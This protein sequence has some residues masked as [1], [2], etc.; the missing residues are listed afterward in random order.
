MM[1]TLVIPKNE[2]LEYMAQNSRVMSENA[3]ET[4]IIAL[5][6]QYGNCYLIHGGVSVNLWQVDDTHIWAYA[7]NAEGLLVYKQLDI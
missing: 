4:A 6:R 3:L 1:P 7:S 2:H 5:W